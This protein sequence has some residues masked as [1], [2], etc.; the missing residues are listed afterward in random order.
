MQDKTQALTSHVIANL[1]LLWK[2]RVG[3]QKTDCQPLSHLFNLSL[4][5]STYST[6]S[7][8]T[9]LD[10][11]SSQ[12]YCTHTTCRFHTY[13]YITGL[14]ENHGEDF[15][16][17]IYIY[18]AIQQ[19]LACLTF[20]EQCVFRPAGSTAAAIL[21]ILHKVTHLLLL[22]NNS[23]VIVIAIMQWIDCSKAFDT[24]RHSTC[25]Q[26]PVVSHPHDRH[27]R[28]KRCIINNKNGSVRHTRL[29]LQLADWLFQ[30]TCIYFI[31]F[32]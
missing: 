8:E 7:V 18:P 24:V 15:S 4:S 27:T 26:S 16:P 19:P 1:N 12:S 6:T 9:S 28:V 13:F 22:V 23:Y 2:E 3:S 29:H 20:D 31:L 11:S 32:I 17:E 10:S 21:T 25:W 14:D 5:A 30:W